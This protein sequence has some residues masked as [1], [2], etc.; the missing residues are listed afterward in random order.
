MEGHNRH[1]AHEEGFLLVEISVLPVQDV[2]GKQLEK[3]ARLGPWLPSRQ[4]SWTML[5]SGVGLQRC[6]IYTGRA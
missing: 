3:Q 2:L 4:E 1:W 6:P 5:G